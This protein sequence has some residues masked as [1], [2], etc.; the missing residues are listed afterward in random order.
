MPLAPS[1]GT[2]LCAPGRLGGKARVAKR[3]HESCV[4][5][6]EDVWHGLDVMV[7]VI[8]NARRGHGPPRV[9]V[10]ALFH[11][12]WANLEATIAYISEV[13]GILIAKVIRCY[14]CRCYVVLC[15]YSVRI[16]INELNYLQVMRFA[17]S[18]A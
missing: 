1:P 2:H 3:L 12:R 5:V 17:L 16:T 13:Q 7:F 9:T 15:K 18:T 10:N 8:R 6:R 4:S 11:N 14:D